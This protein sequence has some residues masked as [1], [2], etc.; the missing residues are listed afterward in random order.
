M[1]PVEISILQNLIN[2]S[3][4]DLHG[5]EMAMTLLE[6]EKLSMILENLESTV[7]EFISKTLA[8]LDFWL[9]LIL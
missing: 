7:G 9:K 1:S 2:V 5:F 6:N 3:I 8:K 4:T